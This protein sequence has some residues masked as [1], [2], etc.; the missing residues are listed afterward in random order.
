MRGFL[1]QKSRPILKCSSGSKFKY[2]K[3]KIDFF[4]ALC[5]VVKSAGIG[6]PAQSR[7]PVLV[8]GWAPRISQTP[9]FG[10]RLSSSESEGAAHTFGH[11]FT[12]NFFVPCERLRSTSYGRLEFLMYF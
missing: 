11:R 6:L 4:T 8:V 3:L 1:P 9:G 5:G 7:A 10:A 2:S 12:A